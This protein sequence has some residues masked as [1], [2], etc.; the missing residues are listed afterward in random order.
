MSMSTGKDKELPLFTD[1][2]ELTML[3]AYHALGM[4]ETAVFS[5]FVRKLP[6]RRNYLLACGLD[7]VLDLLEH[8][9]FEEESLSYIASLSQIPADLIGWLGALRFTGD[10]YAVPEGTPVF[11]N[12]P[13]LEVVAPIAEAQIIET[14]LLNQIQLQTV[15]ASKAARIVTAAGGRLVVD[16][17]CRRAHGIDAALQ[18]ARAFYIGGVSATSNLLAGKRL[19]IPVSGTVAHS[20]IEACASEEEA[21]R[22][23]ASLFPGTTLLVDTYDTIEGVRRV[24]GLLRSD[25][26]LRIGAIRLDSGDLGALSKEARKLLD[27]AGHSHIKIFASGSLSEDRID[28]LLGSGAPIDAFGVGTDMSVSEDAPALDIAYKLTEYAGLGRMKLSTA[29]RTLPGRKQVFRHVQNGVAMGDIIARAD[30]ALPGEPLLRPVMRAGRRI[31][32]FPSL[33]DIR[34]HARQALATL[35]PRITAL[36]PATPPYPVTISP[37]L[38]AEEDAVKRR[39]SQASVSAP[40]Q[41]PR[42]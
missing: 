14:L 20:F 8:F 19:G 21:F 13:I 1:L 32:P 34:T 37:A 22:A 7:S 42:R 5:L 10:V 28:A 25:P 12:E 35:P 36:A 4:A 9:A 33:D 26:A 41:P 39:L 11:A 27:S 18:G 40:A 38:A 29:K 17:G 24:I 3:R 2:Y 15:L 30:E 23:F 6:A 16:F 31:D